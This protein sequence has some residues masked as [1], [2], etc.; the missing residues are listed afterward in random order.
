MATLAQ[1]TSRTI[2]FDHALAIENLARAKSGAAAPIY[3]PFIKIFAAGVLVGSGSQLT[4]TGLAG[5]DVVSSQ[6]VGNPAQAF[7]SGS[8]AGS[9]VTL[10]T[11]AGLTI[12]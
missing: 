6:H 9:P 5:S 2:T 11:T 12:T 10:T 3:Q 7:S 4:I 1:G 8:M